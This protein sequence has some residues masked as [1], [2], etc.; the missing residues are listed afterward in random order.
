MKTMR[1][2]TLTLIAALALTPALFAETQ[3]QLQKEA[4]ISM[5]RAREIALQKAPGGKIADEE[6]EREHGKLI[7]S[8]DIKRGM[9]GVTEVHVDAKNGKVLSMTHESG[10][11]EAAEQKQET[12][13]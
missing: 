5:V 10:A 13:H 6:L 9:H 8:F 4:K 1:F 12:K 2:A 11:K 3:A 7:Y